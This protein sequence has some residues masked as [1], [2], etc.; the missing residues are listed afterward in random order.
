MTPLRRLPADEKGNFLVFFGMSVAVLMGMVALAFDLGRAASTQTDLQSF[1]DSVALAAAAELDGEADSI[2]RAVLAARTLIADRQS[3]GEDGQVLTTDDSALNDADF[4]LTFLTALPADDSNVDD[5]GAVICTAAACDSA[6][7]S[8]QQSAIYVRADVAEHT[9]RMNFASALSA[10][11]GGGRMDAR[12]AATATAGYTQFACAITPMMFCLPDGDYTADA[13]IGDMI[14]LRSGGSGAAWGPGD[15][16][17]I[18]PTNL[19]IDPNGPCASGNLSGRNLYSC[20]VGADGPLTQCV[21]TR[22]QLMTEPG[23]RNGVAEAAFNVR[24]DIYRATMSGEANVEAYRPAPNVVKG[25]M[26]NGGPRPGNACLGGN[27]E[28]TGNSIALP[29]DTCF[30]SG[31][32]PYARVGDGVW[33]EAEYVRRNHNNSPIATAPG[34]LPALDGTRY[35]MYLNEIAAAATSTAPLMPATDNVT[36]TARWTPQ[37]N[38]SVRAVT[39]TGRP[40]CSPYQSDDPA[41]R[42]IIAAGVDCTANPVS[43]RS[44]VVVEE[45]FRIFLTEPARD[46]GAS[47]PNVDITGEIIGSAGLQGGGGNSGVFHDVVQLYR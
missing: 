22:G 36:G 4:T 29:R 2:A 23:Q 10:L 45:F 17:F 14:I 47:P 27:P 9:V 33:D 6:G 24:F 37:A 35:Q 8:A 34:A 46:D 15:F 5:A 3:F 31:D 30:A 43:G 28:P 1:A 25:V 11:Q 19:A 16:G 26:R 12:V 7:A 38:G 39:E 20:L 41:R 42:V 44:P 18:D 13:N 40:M 21:M 32:C